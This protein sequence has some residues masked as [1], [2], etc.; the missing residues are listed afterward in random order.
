[1]MIN[2]HLLGSVQESTW[3][4]LPQVV[5]IRFYRIGKMPYAAVNTGGTN[6]ISTSDPAE[7]QRLRSYI[8]GHQLR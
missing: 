5:S 2:S 8:V 3:I 4:N 7:V 1:M 6:F